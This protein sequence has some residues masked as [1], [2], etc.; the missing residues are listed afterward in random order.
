MGTPKKNYKEQ[1]ELVSPTIVEK[2]RL[3][4]FGK[5]IGQGLKLERFSDVLDKVKEI[6]LPL[7]SWL[8]KPIFPEAALIDYSTPKKFQRKRGLRLFESDIMIIWLERSGMWFVRLNALYGLGRSRAPFREVDSQGLAEIIFRR[9]EDILKVFRRD[10]NILKHIPFLRDAALYNLILLQF[11]SKSSEAAR[12]LVEKRKKRLEIID[13]RLDLLDEFSQSLDPITV[14]GGVILKEYWIL[15]EESDD[16]HKSRCTENFLC[17]EALEP[18]FEVAKAKD[19]DS[20]FVTIVDERDCE[21]LGDLLEK[22]GCMS[23]NVKDGAE[24][25]DISL[26]F[27]NI[28]HRPSFSEKELAALKNLIDSITIA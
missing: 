6:F 1:R 9:S 22:I 12:D 8:D 4:E 27:N 11:L 13:Q 16:I 19:T 24:D 5:G 14:R 3:L 17:P 23:K 10:S 21:D 2:I 25:T 7:V 28:I 15:E 18:L 20:T 26:F